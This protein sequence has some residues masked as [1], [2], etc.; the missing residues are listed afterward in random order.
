[1]GRIEEQAMQPGEPLTHEQR[2]LLTYLPTFTSMAIAAS[3]PEYLT[4]I[5][6][7]IN[8]EELCAL[9]KT[10]YLKNLKQNPVRLERAIASVVFKLNRH[11]MWSLLQQAGVK[12]RRS[13]WDRF[14]LFI[15]ALLFIAVTTAIM[16]LAGSNLGPRPNG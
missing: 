3:G 5:P 8:Y 15:A 12:D 4:P 6:R 16:P 11:P 10:A 2:I 7:D 13:G 1:V 9:G 14:L